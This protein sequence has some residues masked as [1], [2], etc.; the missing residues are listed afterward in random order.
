MGSEH[1][2]DIEGDVFTRLDIPD[3][4]P[5]QPSQIAKLAL[6]QTRFQAEGFDIPREGVA[7]V[8]RNRRRRSPSALR[9]SHAC[10][11]ISH[12]C[13]YS[14]TSSLKAWLSRC[15]RRASPAVNELS[16]TSSSDSTIISTSG[17]IR[18][19]RSNL[20][21]PHPL[22]RGRLAPSKWADSS[23]VRGRLYPRK[24]ADAWLWVRPQKVVPHGPTSVPTLRRSDSARLLVN[25]PKA[26]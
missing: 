11:N 15:R 14:P 12:S 26:D 9:R 21:S 6:R 25:L 24:W 18:Q 8:W 7:Q 16:T 10:L 22:V 5:A 13:V 20:Y 17:P 19:I 2:D 3:I 1:S 23:L 4:F